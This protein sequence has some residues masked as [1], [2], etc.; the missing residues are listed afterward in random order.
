MS[1]FDVS[2]QLEF[3]VTPCCDACLLACLQFFDPGEVL[4]LYESPAG[5]GL[6]TLRLVGWLWFI[7]AVFFTLKHHPEKAGF[8]YPF[9]VFYSVW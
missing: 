1:S 7:Y 6:I 9:F 5:Y 8:Y 4:Y 2:N 3:Y